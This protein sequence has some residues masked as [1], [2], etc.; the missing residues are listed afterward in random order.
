MDNVVVT[1]GTRGIGLAI[2]RQLGLSGFQVVAVSRS[3]NPE[4]AAAMQEV[5]DSGA[6]RLR[7]VSSDLAKIEELPNLAHNIRVEFGPIYGLVNNAGTSVEGLLATM[8][9]LQIEQLLRMNTLSP[10]ILTKYIVRSM[11]SDGRGRIVNISSI[12]ASTGFSALSVYAA[13]K[14]SMIGF[15]KSL[16]REVG[17][18][19]ITV[20]AVAPGFVDTQLTAS[21]KGEQRE[22]VVRRSA[23]RRLAEV[24]DVAAAVDY[25]LSEKGRNV[26]GTVITVDAGSTA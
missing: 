9:T 23:L 25:L 13:S 12:I 1:G 24:G 19:G 16:A 3:S 11:M 22:R 14:A 21:L 20:N 18:L 26:T 10:I 17:K 5:E 8:H 15:T 7:F 4:F 6:G 2:A